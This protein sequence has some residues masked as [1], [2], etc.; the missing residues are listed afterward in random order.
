MEAENQR[1]LEEGHRGHGA[2]IDDD[3]D[4]DE[5]NGTLE[6]GDQQQDGASVRVRAH[7]V[8]NA[9]GGTNSAGQDINED[10]LD[11]TEQDERGAV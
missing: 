2:D 10:M 9:R 11:E 1:R 3:M 8:S 5:N 4:I 6:E 7:D